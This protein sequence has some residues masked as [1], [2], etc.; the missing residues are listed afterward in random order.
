M[1]WVI[2]E[3]RDFNLSLTGGVFKVDSSEAGADGNANRYLSISA[4]DSDGVIRINPGTESTIFFNREVGA[5]KNLHIWDGDAN[6]VF[7]SDGANRRIGVRTATPRQALEVQGNVLISGGNQLMLHDNGGNDALRGRLFAVTESPHI[8]LYAADGADVGIQDGGTTN[9][10]IEGSNG[11]V[12]IGTNSPRGKL[13]VNGRIESG[14]TGGGVGDLRLYDTGNNSIR[15]RGVGANSFLTDMEGTGAIGNWEMRDFNLNL[16]G[17]VFKIGSSEAGADANGNR[18]F[19]IS[20]YDSDG[21]VRINPG[22][23]STLYLNREVGAARNFHVWDGNA[24]QVLSTIGATRRVGIGT[25]NPGSKL[26]VA[27]TVRAERLCDENGNNCRDLSEAVAGGESKWKDV[28]SGIAYNQGNV[29]INTNSPTGRLHVGGM[30]SDRYVMFEARANNDEI[31]VKFRTKA[32]NG[33]ITTPSVIGKPGTS[34]ANNAL[35]MSSDGTFPNAVARGERLGVGTASPAETLHVNGNALISNGKQLQLRT[36][37]NNLRGQFWASDSS[38][39]LTMRTSSGEDIAFQ[40]SGTTNMFIEGTNGH[41]G[42]GTTSPSG[43]LHVAG[44]IE[45]GLTN[46]TVGDLGS[47]TAAITPCEL[48][49]TVPTA[50]SL[51]W[52]APAPLVTGKFVTS[53]SA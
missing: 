23:E 5:K 38:P 27:G 26:H 17:G 49:V 50:F 45:S 44:R 9:L 32:A 34:G 19:S 43:R 37:G 46:G 15:T 41:V 53:T 35:W 2:G 22:P 4:Y 3:V 20:A 29:A 25:T 36:S 39:H 21:V 30:R 1:R 7:A 14:N 13:H 33:Q 11:N 47:M 31:P 10:F 8:R 52:K 24:S 18:F 16:T 48:A 6:P 28:N 51:I 12:G 40:D 42:I